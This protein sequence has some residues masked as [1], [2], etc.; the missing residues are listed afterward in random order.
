MDY[1]AAFSSGKHGEGK[2]PEL[3]PRREFVPATDE[4]VAKL[5]E[6]LQYSL[7][8]RLALLGL[9]YLT[10]LEVALAIGVACAPWSRVWEH[11]V[12][13]VVALYILPPVVARF[14]LIAFP[15]RPGRISI[16]SGGFFT[17]WALVNL[18]MIYARFTFL[19]EFL[20]IV[21]SLYSMWLRLWGAKI[22]RLTYWGAGVRVLDRSFIHIGNDVIIGA[23]VC[24]SPHAFMRSHEGNIELQLAPIFIGDRALLG[25]YSLLSPGTEIAPGECTHAFLICQPY[26]S[27]KGGRRTKPAGNDNPSDRFLEWLQR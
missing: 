8:Q 26:V 23:G 9:N 27:F 18:Q 6:E 16:G 11:V 10:M 2:W 13:P 3:L 7:W 17:W 19:E 5:V 1:A 24:L 21:P 15:I 22:G 14:I 4:G 25:G 12:A 20:R